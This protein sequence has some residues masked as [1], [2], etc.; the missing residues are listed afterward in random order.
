MQEIQ[1]IGVEA[2]AKLLGCN[3]DTLYRWAREKKV[4]AIRLGGKVRFR[5][6]TLAEWMAAQE[7]AA[8]RGGDSA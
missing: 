2:A 3:K 1:T 8:M 6:A 7:Q 4:P 5:V